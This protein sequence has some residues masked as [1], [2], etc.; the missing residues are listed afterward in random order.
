MLCQHFLLD[1]AS[2]LLQIELTGDVIEADDSVAIRDNEHVVFGWILVSLCGV[3]FA[4]E[5]AKVGLDSVVAAELVR[6]RRVVDEDLSRVVIVFWGHPVEFE[7]PKL[8][9][10]LQAEDALDFLVDW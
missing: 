6:D 7:I 10:R 2:D 3:V 8:G 9:L 5:E 4:L 1:L